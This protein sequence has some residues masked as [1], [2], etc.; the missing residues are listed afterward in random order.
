MAFCAARITVRTLVAFVTLHASVSN[1]A[2]DL[3]KKVVPSLIAAGGGIARIEELLAEQ[4]D[5]ADKPDALALAPGPASFR[6]ER[7]SFEYEPGRPCVQDVS[8]EIKAGEN[9]AFVGPSGSGKS[10]VLEFLL[11]FHDPQK[12]RVIMRD[13]DVRDLSLT[14]LHGHIGAVFQDPLL[15][16][17]SIRDNIRMGKLDASDADR[18]GKRICGFARLA[19]QLLL[20]L[21]Q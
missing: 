21:E 6:L 10:T 18:N 11:R 2:Y 15:L 19:D 4:V 5:I 8:L 16:A 7:V 9:V 1:K 14:A 12:G 17:G 3:A 20:V 13:H